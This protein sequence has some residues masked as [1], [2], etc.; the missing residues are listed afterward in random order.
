[1]AKKP[2]H[3]SIDKASASEKELEKTL[4]RLQESLGDRLSLFHRMPQE[5]KLTW[6]EKDALMAELVRFGE[7]IVRGKHDN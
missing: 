5:K 7:L 3:I 4:S 1:M 6:L 2:K